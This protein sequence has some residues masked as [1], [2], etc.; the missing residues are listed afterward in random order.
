MYSN[1]R[2]SRFNILDLVVKIIFFILF[3]LVLLWLF[4]KVPNMT[5]FYSNVFRENISYMQE[6][7]ESYFT[8]DKMPKEIGDE[9]KIT[10]AELFNKKLVLPFV[11]KDGNS[12]NQYESFVSI[13]KNED[14]SYSLKTNLVCNEE[15][16][17]LIKILGCHNYCKDNNCSKTCHKEQI[18]QYQFKK[19]ITKTITT[20]SCPS[21]YTKDGNYCY[22]SVLKD[23]KSA[24]KTTITD[25]VLT[26]EAK[27]I[28]VEGSKLKLDVIKEKKS[29][30]QKLVYDTVVVSSTPSSTKQEA[31]SCPQQSCS[32]SCAPTY[33][34][35]CTTHT[36]NHQQVTTCNTCGGG[37]SESCTT[38][39]GTCYRTVTVPGSTTYSCPAASTANNGKTDSGLQC[40][41]YE[42]IDNGY[43]YSCPLEANTTTGSNE[44]LECYKV[45]EGKTYLQCTD[46]TYT[47][48]NGV[49]KKTITGTSTELKCE[50]SGYILEG[51]SCNLYGT[52]KEKASSSTSK[53]TTYKYTWSDKSTLSGWT[54]TGKTKTIEGEEVCE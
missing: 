37:C 42:T 29:D 47:L 53:K 12:C 46:S 31:Y 18:V 6:A 27:K 19:A 17:Y 44:T 24:I 33:S 51:T 50:D 9:V 45:T 35:N 1:E 2:G 11:D 23:T 30:T 39:S 34:C 43:K 5:P 32:T 14:E 4:P 10:L 3:V 52:D 22:K 40:W 48:T 25:Q 20:Y 21:G 13:T 7:G 54:K 36:V 8:D 49:C 41:H 38:T 28:Y 26:M 15:S 16:D